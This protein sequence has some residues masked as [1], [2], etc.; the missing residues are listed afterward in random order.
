MRKFNKIL[1]VIIA[2][3]TGFS[4]L[5]AQECELPV[6]DREISFDAYLNCVGR[7]NLEFLANKLNVSIAD[8]ELAAAK[9]MPDPSL[10][11]EGSKESFSLGLSYT[12][13]LGKRRFRTGLARSQK[14][15]EQLA[16]EQNFQDL[17]A[18]AAELYADAMLQKELLNVKKSS[19]QYML[20]LSRSDSLRYV[21]GEVNENDARQ[22]KLEAVTLLNDVFDQESACYSA[23]EELNRFMGVQSDTLRLP[24]GTWQKLECKYTLPELLEI[25][26]K[27]RADLLAAVKNVE[28]SRRAYKLASAERRPDI[29]LSVSY[30]RDW[31]HFWPQARYLTFGVSIPLTIS[32]G[33][34]GER[35]AA[36]Y[37]INQ[38]ELM[39]RDMEL[40]VQSEIKQAW[41]AF[42]AEKKKIDQYLQGVL[43]DSEKVLDG[44]VYQYRRG[45][46]S[47][48]DVL[49]AQRTYNEVQQDYLETMKG[50]VT[51]LVGLEK[52]CGIWDI[53]F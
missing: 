8:A 6:Q 1:L 10:D 12:L 40:Q 11:F 7:Q 52:S 9:V 2:A 35:R 20:E 31:H 22:S 29:D 28:V 13:E 16:L 36:K 34:K 18:Q 32:A 49:M 41:Y 47:I 44:T 42:E 27:G 45:E 46:A 21:A 38:A 19:Y 4:R 26:S 33:N 30:E 25:G 24:S 14:E 15:Y 23:L 50:Y 51:A 53:H 17:R 5:G 37:G 3:L 43:G 48:L 39:Q